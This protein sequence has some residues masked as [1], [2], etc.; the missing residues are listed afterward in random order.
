[1]AMGD[2]NLY[3]DCLEHHAK[4][5][6]L[7]ESTALVQHI[8]FP[9]HQH[10]HRTII[11][12]AHPLLIPICVIT[13]WLLANLTSVSNLVSLYSDHLDSVCAIIIIIIIITSF[14]Q[15]IHELFESDLLRHPPEDLDGLV[16]S[17]NST[18]NPPQSQ[19]YV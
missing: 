4:F 18:L 6:D 3:L 15:I 11:S 12:Y 5:V 10:D 13:V 17:H 9:T 1:M 8:K 19:C 16:S 14:K 7:L 2:F